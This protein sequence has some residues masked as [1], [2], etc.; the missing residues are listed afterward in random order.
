MPKTSAK[1]DPRVEMAISF[2]QSCPAATVKEEMM[3]AG[4]S[5]E[6]IKD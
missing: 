4:F 5:K 6:E 2:L 3:I 1:V